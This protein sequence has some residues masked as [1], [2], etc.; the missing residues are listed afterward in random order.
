MI[1]GLGLVGLESCMQ[2]LNHMSQLIP[3]SHLITIALGI[4]DESHELLSLH[5]FQIN[6]FSKIWIETKIWDV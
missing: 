6:L 1:H 2:E 4:E 3:H 5:L